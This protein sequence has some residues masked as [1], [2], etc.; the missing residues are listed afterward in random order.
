M[1]F[2]YSYSHSR[3]TALIVSTTRYRYRTISTLPANAYNLKIPFV[4]FRNYYL[5]IIIKK[6]TKCNYRK[7]FHAKN[8]RKFADHNLKNCVFGPWPW[9]CVLASR[10]P[11]LS[12]E[13]VCPQKVGPWPWSRNFLSPWLRPRTLCPRLHL[14]LHA[15]RILSCNSHLLW[16]AK[17]FDEDKNWN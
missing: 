4:I 10:I 13:R 17:I 9:S 8:N 7:Y 12:L 2:S 3:V 11:A 14:A 6:F 5:R 1:D 15:W 16:K